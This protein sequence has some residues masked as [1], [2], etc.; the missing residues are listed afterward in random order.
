VSELD[1]RA[2]GERAKQRVEQRD[3]LL[4]HG[5]EL[6]K[7]WTKSLAKRRHPLAKDSSQADAVESL[8][9]IGEA[10]VRL[11]AKAKFGRRFGRPLEER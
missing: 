7:D 8:G 5:W 4:P 9:R 1:R 11:H 2:S 6:Q 10:T 3:I